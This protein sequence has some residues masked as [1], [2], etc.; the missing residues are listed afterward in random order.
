MAGISGRTE[1]TREFGSGKSYA[2]SQRENVRGEL[3]RRDFLWIPLMFQ[4]GQEI[5]LLQ[6]SASSQKF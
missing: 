5:I 4:L 3:L 2:A 1:G 6:G